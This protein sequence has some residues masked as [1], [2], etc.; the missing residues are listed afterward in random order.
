MKPCP[1][2]AKELIYCGDYY[3][4]NAL[5]TFLVEAF[6]HPIN[7]CAL[8]GLVFIERKWNVRPLE[9]AF[10]DRI[11][12]LETELAKAQNDSIVSSASDNVKTDCMACS[13]EWTATITTLKAESNSIHDLLTGCGFEITLVDG[14]VGLQRQGVIYFPIKKD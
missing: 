8:S 6:T 11:A 7:E 2:C 14:R 4:V 3:D 9:D 13:T 5:G 10:K 12:Y 1:F